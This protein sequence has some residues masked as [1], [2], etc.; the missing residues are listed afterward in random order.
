MSALSRAELERWLPHRSPFL[1][2]DYAEDFV[3]RRS[4]T[5]VMELTEDSPHFAG[6]FPGRPVLPGVL[7][8]EAMAQ[9]GAALSAKSENLD[10]ANALLMLAIVESARFRAPVYPGATLRLNVEQT[11][12]RHGLYRYR[13]EARVDGRR[14]GEAVFAAKLVETS[15]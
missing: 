15:E 5:G 8:I 12:V 2:L 14:A 9:T 4:L 6:H 3:P 13:G 7:M 11:E 1:L 10:P